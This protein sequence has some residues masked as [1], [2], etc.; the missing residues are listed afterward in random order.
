MYLVI[1]H[2]DIQVKNRSVIYK[3]KCGQ[4][5]NRLNLWKIIAVEETKVDESAQ[6]W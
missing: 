6:L 3:N 5:F 2:T 4:Y 1:I